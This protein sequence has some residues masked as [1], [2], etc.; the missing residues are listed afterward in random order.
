MTTEYGYDLFS[1]HDYIIPPGER[2]LISTGVKY[3]PVPGTVGMITGII[4]LA[5]KHG[6]DVAQGVLDSTYNDE[7]K[8][9]MYNHDRY[10]PYYIKAGYRV[11]VMTLINTHVH[12]IYYKVTGV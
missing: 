3:S 8:V 4:G 11:A 9:L 6:V 7:I 12:P 5:V 10:E 2:C 1:S